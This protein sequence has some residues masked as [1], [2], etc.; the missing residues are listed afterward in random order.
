MPMNIG[1]FRENQTKESRTFIMEEN[2]IMCHGTVGNFDSKEC[3][4][5]VCVLGHRVHHLQSSFY[6]FALICYLFLHFGD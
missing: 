1:H 6:E 3:L 2:E 4:G 5:N